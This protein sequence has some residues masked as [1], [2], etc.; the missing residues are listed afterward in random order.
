MK[1][2]KIPIVVTGLGCSF[3]ECPTAD[4]LAGQLRRGLQAAT[5]VPRPAGATVAQI[6]DAA[7]ADCL[8]EA[9]PP[10]MRKGVPLALVSVTDGNSA[11][12]PSA[13]DSALRAV[14]IAAGLSPGAI[15]ATASVAKAA[16]TATEV[17]RGTRRLSR[18]RTP[19]SRSKS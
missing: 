12:I 14:A 3:S 8:R 11:F 15:A 5:A 2:S 16:S 6:R 10:A 18:R 4:A 1:L 19:V 9:V 13:G 17:A 7:L